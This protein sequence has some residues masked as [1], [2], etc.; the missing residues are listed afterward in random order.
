M[1]KRPI[2][3]LYLTISDFNLEVK[4]I[5][6]DVINTLIEKGIKVTLVSAVERKKGVRTHFEQGKLL[7][8]LYVKTPNIYNTNVIEKG[9]SYL[10]VQ[11]LFISAIK[12][13]LSHEQFDLILYTTP[14][15]TIG[16]LVNWAK[17]YYGA[18]SY[19]ML[20]DI[21]PQNAIDLGMIKKGGILHHFFESK[22]KE[23]YRASDFIG[24]M[25]PANVKYVLHHHPY[26][27]ESQVRV[28]PNAFKK[29]A[30]QSI[31]EEDRSRI[32]KKLGIPDGATLFIYGG[33]LGKPQGLPFVTEALKHCQTIPNAYFLL[34]GKGTEYDKLK[35]DLGTS[36]LDNVKLISFLPKEDYD[37]I[38]RAA[39]VGLVFLDYRFT[40]P[41][42]PSRILS[43]LDASIPVL[44][45]T[46]PI[47]DQGAIA[48]ANGFGKY[49]PSNS[50]K[51]FVCAVEWYTKNPSLR[52]TMG[53]KGRVFMDQNYTTEEVYQE[54]MNAVSSKKANQS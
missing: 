18:T 50:V 7:N 49:V 31:S 27:Q 32:R 40:F 34:I 54:I 23:L 47:C 46:D 43:Y 42:F 20:K 10:L 41:N 24:C 3:I 12:R 17:R 22:E 11:P 16:R 9:L 21:F 19:L 25:S 5:Y 33:N 45:A 13:Y 35:K 4:H 36:Q 51:D 53:A 52:T 28:C 6:S 2:N 39:D 44:V 1:E 14:P 30:Y 26:L 48:E 38:V 15:P 29:T 37:Q 8:R